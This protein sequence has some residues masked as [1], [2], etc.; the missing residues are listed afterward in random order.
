MR[1]GAVAVMAAVLLTTSATAC[2]GG[3]ERVL[4]VFAA[5]S[6]TDVFTE[7]EH[8]FERTHDGVDVRLNFAGS[9]RLA[10]QIAEGAPADVFASADTEPMAR[11][12]EDGLLEGPAV[13]FAT[14]TLTIAVPPGNPAN[15]TGLADLVAPDLT[16]VVCAPSVP[17]GAAAKQ[18]QRLAGVTLRPASEEADVRSV[19]TKVEVGEADAGLV[20][21]TDTAASER[22]EAVEFPEAAEVVNT[23]PVAVLA[24]A[25]EPSLARR[26][27][28]L[29]LSEEGGRSL[30]EAGFGL[31]R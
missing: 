27:V 2:G 12:A 8:R 20:Y 10:Q 19:L 11:L 7:L 17:C 24:D 28:D 18:V 3:G 26:F 9:S 30:R 31:P 1:R 15:V 29:V 14:N 5:A 6:L 23:Y 21:V 22:V 4:T 25:G 16:V 13:P